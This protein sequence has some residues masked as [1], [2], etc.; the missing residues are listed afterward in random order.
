[1]S[2]RLQVILSDDEM[3]DL[4]RLARSQSSTVSELVRQS[5]RSARHSRASKAPT[6]KTQV[7]RH[8]AQFAF[9]TADIGDLLDQIESGYTAGG[10]A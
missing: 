5:L 2:K 4:K 3:R 9:P 10:G 7:V 6:L 1:M 8:A